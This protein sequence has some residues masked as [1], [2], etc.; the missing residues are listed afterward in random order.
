MTDFNTLGL[1]APILRALAEKNHVH[2]TPIQLQAI[3]PVLQGRDLVGIAQTGTGKTAAF[4][5]PILN[6]L[7][8]NPS[9][10]HPER[11]TVRALILAPTRELAN[12]YSIDAVKTYGRQ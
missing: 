4:A 12:Q 10:A 3:P 8:A 6:R 2:P 9:A 5:L 1:A 11:G 7:A